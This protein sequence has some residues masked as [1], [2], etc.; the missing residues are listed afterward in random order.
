MA[1]EVAPVGHRD[2][3]I[4]DFSSKTVEHASVLSVPFGAGNGC[5]RL[6]VYYTKAMTAAQSG[7][8]LKQPI[9]ARTRDAREW[10]AAYRYNSHGPVTL[11]LIGIRDLKQINERHGRS[12]GDAAIRQVGH[13][14][15]Q[16]GAMQSPAARIAAKLPGREFLIV[17]DG[18]DDETQGAKL[19]QALLDTLSGNLGLGAEK[20]HINARIGFALS[21]EGEDGTGLHFRATD[22]LSKAY[23]RKGSRQAAAQSQVSMDYRLQA[24]LDTGLRAAIETDQIAIMLQPQF[25]VADGRLVGAE[26]LARWHHPEL[27]EIGAGQ[28]FATADRCD[29][30]EELSLLIQRKAIGLAAQWSE[31]LNPLRL[32]VNLGADELNEGY[33]DRLIIL[34]AQTGFSAERLTLELTEE[35]LIRD[36][37]QAAAQLEKLRDHGVRIAVDDFG[38][39]YSSLAYL[40]A[41]PLDYLKLDKGMTPDIVGIGKDRIVLRAIIAM[42]KALELKIIAEGIETELELEMLRAEGCDYFQGFLRSPPLSAVEFENFALLAN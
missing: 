16:F 6:S 19:A 40:K 2:T 41:L 31:A 1:P 26:A 22:A 5:E 7:K 30:R 25:D 3:E 15:A 10:L 35:S 8:R 28:L 14:I 17:L 9:L 12:V 21:E 37:D 36:I 42:A 29:M 11:F 20:L 34:L 23:A 13:K 4:V 38:T 24:A 39:G 18:V 27:G 32:A 33:S